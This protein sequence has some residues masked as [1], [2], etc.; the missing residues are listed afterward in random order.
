M[1]K[2]ELLIQICVYMPSPVRIGSTVLARLASILWLMDR[3]VPSFL[4]CAGEK[5]RPLYPQSYVL[6]AAYGST[7]DGGTTVHH[8][9]VLP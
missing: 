1:Y 9:I 4:V 5:G 8:G 3:M 2:S 6:R 7:P